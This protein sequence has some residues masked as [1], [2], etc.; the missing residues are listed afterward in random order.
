M[1]H[2]LARCRNGSSWTISSPGG[3]AAEI[4]DNSE[5]RGVRRSVSGGLSRNCQ[6]VS[7]VGI[8][9]QLICSLRATPQR[10]S[11]RNAVR[12]VRK[13]LDALLRRPGILAA[14]FPIIVRNTR[15][16]LHRRPKILSANK[17]LEQILGEA[18]ANPHASAV[19]E[20]ISRVD[21]P[22]VTETTRLVLSL[23]QGTSW[24]TR[25]RFA[26]E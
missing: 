16:R 7:N 18:R 13:W 25:S 11:P 8:S 1:A 23:V 20:C 17:K 19:L 26:G 6:F 2:S 24:R 12:I 14:V 9:K 22:R 4:S 10:S 21:S 3:T 15:S 5:H